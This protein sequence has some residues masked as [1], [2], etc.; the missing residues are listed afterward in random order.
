M[1]YG[2]REIG[3]QP[4][5]AREEFV[6]NFVNWAAE[7]SGSRR[8]MVVAGVGVIPAYARPSDPYP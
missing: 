8:C 2:C 1:P 5:T 7:K 4:V 3:H 6:R